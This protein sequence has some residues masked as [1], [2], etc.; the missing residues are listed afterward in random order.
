MMRTRLVG[1]VALALAIGLG[2][3]LGLGVGAPAGAQD[4][5]DC[6]DFASQ[7][8][9][10][11]ALRAD[12][13][14]PAENDADGDGIACELVEYEN[15]AIDFAPVAAAITA[16]APTATAT[17]TTTAVTTMPGSGTGSAL[18]GGTAGWTD[19]SV[20]FGLF[21][22]AAGCGGMALRRMRHAA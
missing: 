9:A 16:S 13:T 2:L 14:D 20:A 12:P 15:T 6:A 4:A 18:T 7:A 21:G 1:S 8:E 3:A 11:A 5:L 10:Q 17:T 22:L 19:A